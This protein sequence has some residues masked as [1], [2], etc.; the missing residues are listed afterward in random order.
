MEEEEE[1]EAKTGK[2]FTFFPH[3]RE[4]PLSS[5]VVTERPKTKKGRILVI[6]CH[7]DIFFIPPT[8]QNADNFVFVVRSLF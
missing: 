4:C 3:C 1:E 7:F 6:L 2:S 5:L 8:L